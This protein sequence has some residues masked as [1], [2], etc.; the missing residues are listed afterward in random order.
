MESDLKSY[1]RIISGKSKG[2]KI[3]FLKT[4][5]TRPL[6]DSV[7][8]SI[9]NI[10]NHSNLFN[11][12]LEKTNVLDLYSGFGSFG[13]ECLSRGANNITFIEKDKT[14]AKI[15]KKNLI[16]LSSQEKAIVIINEIEQF[17][18]REKLEKFEII[19]LDPP[20]KE[21]TYLDVLKNIKK[22]KIFKKNHIVI[23]HRE[24]RS[25]DNLNNILTP[26]LIKHYGRSKI[27]FGKFLS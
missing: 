13:L 16:S 5:T 12:N 9:F 17:L 18:N 3:N 7:R 22:K 21:N 15:L 25:S 23:I 1:M 11:I 6:K 20:F 2:K 14:V 10:I 8:E 24:K 4:F 26:L 19:F 27:I